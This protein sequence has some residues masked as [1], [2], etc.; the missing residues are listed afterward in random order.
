MR[1]ISP[2]ARGASSLGVTLSRWR[3]EE[4]RAGARQFTLV[5]QPGSACEGR[6]TLSSFSR[7]NAAAGSRSGARRALPV[8]KLKQAWCPPASNR[9]AYQ[10]SFRKRCAAAGHVRYR[11]D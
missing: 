6:E 8:R 3:V 10:E 7:T 11:T 2:S 5:E 9:I 4:L 1:G